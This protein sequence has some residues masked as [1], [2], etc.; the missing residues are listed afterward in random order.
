M[1]LRHPRRKHISLNEGQGFSLGRY[2]RRQPIAR[3]WHTVRKRVAATIACLNTVF[4]G[5]IAGIYAGEVPR[6]QY[7]IADISHKVILGNV[8]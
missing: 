5:L 8:L 6:I 3:E 2:H 1:S 4:I 7:T